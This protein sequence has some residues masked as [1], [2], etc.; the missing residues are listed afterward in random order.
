VTYAWRLA[1]SVALRLRVHNEHRADRVR[2]DALAALARWFDSW[3]G[4]PDGKGWPFGRNIYVSEIY[5]V[6]STVPGVLEVMPEVSGT[7]GKPEPEIV[8][9][10]VASGRLRYNRLRQ[11][12]AVE[13]LDNELPEFNSDQTRLIL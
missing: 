5:Q 12:E 6:L 1:F 4:G 9:S 2:R 10:D 3:V 13:L 11:L 8:L 7:S